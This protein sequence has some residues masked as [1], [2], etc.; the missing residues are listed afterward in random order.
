MTALC[1]Q[2]DKALYA[3]QTMPRMQKKS[4]IN[5]KIHQK[6]TYAILAHKTW[7]LALHNMIQEDHI[8]FMYIKI[9][10]R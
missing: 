1:H 6:S 5:K 2:Q 7:D 9:H 4:L 10:L 3:Q 8:V